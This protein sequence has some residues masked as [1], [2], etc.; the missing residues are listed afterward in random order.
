MV[1]ATSLIQTWQPLPPTCKD[2]LSSESPA[3]T[4]C[5]PGILHFWGP[6]PPTLFWANELGIQVGC[7]QPP[8]QDPRSPLNH[9][10]L[11]EAH[12][13]LWGQ[14][15]GSGMLEYWLECLEMGVGT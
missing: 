1:A 11:G 9:L 13:S 8:S 2:M 7:S 12:L 6:P 14:A 3:S 15:G 10:S 5:L 4:G